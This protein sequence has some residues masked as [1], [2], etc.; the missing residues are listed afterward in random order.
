MY[1]LMLPICPSTWFRRSLYP[2]PTLTTEFFPPRQHIF[3]HSVHTTFVGILLSHSIRS[4][5]AKLGGAHTHGET[6]LAILLMIFMTP[7]SPAI[8]GQR[9]MSAGFLLSIWPDLT[10]GTLYITN[11]HVF[12]RPWV[13]SMIIIKVKNHWVNESH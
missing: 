3:M 7:T 4:S 6:P 12:L 2:F 9:W 11:M 5:A 8:G 10:Y 13:G 1:A